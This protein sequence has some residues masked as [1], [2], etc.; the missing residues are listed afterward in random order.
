MKIWAFLK[1]RDEIVREGNVHRVLETI[2]ACGCSGG[3]L[4]DDASSDGTAEVLETFVHER[5]ALGENW[6]LL[7]VA[8][9]DHDFAR[10]MEVKQR[11]LEKLHELASPVPPSWI[12]WL[13]ADEV[14]LDPAGLRAELEALP[15]DVP[16]LAM[17][18]VQAWRTDDWARVDGGFDDGWFVKAWR[19]QPDLSFDVDPGT[20]RQ[21]FPKQIP[22]HAC[23]RSRTEI[24]H[25]GNVGKNL[26]W[27]AIQYA[28]G[29]GGVDRHLA[30]GHPPSESLAT[31]IGFDQ[32]AWSEPRPRYRPLQ[33][34]FQSV[35]T[36]FT[37]DE[38]RRVRAMGRLERQ[39]ETFAVILP[40]FDRGPTL[41]RA[42]E[43]L[44]AQTWERWICLVL[45]DGSTDDTPRIMR[46][47]QDRD[48]RVF[49]ARYP[50]NRGGVAMNEIGMAMACSM[51]EWWSRL[52]SDDWWGP[53]KLE[54]DAAAL[55]DHD[56]CYGPFTVVRDGRFCEV[57]NPEQDP[58]EIRAELLAGRFRVSWANVAARTSALR[59]VR[60][61]FGGFC[62][63]RLRNCEDF[64]LNA[65]LA[66]TGTRFRFRS[67]E[68]DLDAIWTCASSGGASSPDHARILA[69]DERLTR[70]LIARGA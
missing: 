46:G 30:F 33:A 13:D 38:I 7:R 34:Q 59:R 21:Q 3:I 40:T 60:E 16:G 66:A 4:C 55:R 22:F 57:C 28:G 44:L 24:L 50:D 20:H 32:A 31:G 6:T 9:E 27:K 53:R 69:E 54:R 29:L 19:Y 67:N 51:T 36:P 12:L 47:W 42:L 61:R 37:L 25:R 17:H 41:A 63:P 2:E 43:S 1:A 52:G 15:K 68:G 5:N 23:A 35:P 58:E 39:P 62:D 64:L 45:D 14:V 49:Y 65:R 8:P 56:A 11:M 10:E 18:Y 26:V 70:E 48:P